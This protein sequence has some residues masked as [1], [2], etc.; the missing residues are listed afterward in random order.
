MM[1]EAIKAMLASRHGGGGAAAVATHSVG[2]SLRCVGVLREA[3]ER[4]AASVA[5]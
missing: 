5:G 4:A 1:K 3:S 2:G